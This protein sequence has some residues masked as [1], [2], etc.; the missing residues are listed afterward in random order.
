MSIAGGGL[1]VV[2]AALAALHFYWGFGGVWPGSDPQSLSERVAG[3]S[4]NV[5]SKFLPCAIVAVAL[6]S[7]A[8]IVFAGQG[9]L[10]YGLPELIVYGGYATLILV[11]ALRG[12]APYLT[13]VF[14]YARGTPFFELNRRYYAPLCLLIAAVLVFDYP[15]GLNGA[16]ADL[17]GTET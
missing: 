13:P 9:N 7:A 8:A 12:L 11:F 16:M 3:T 17:F 1:I 5:A 15:P 4:R 2:L 14:N 6:L 10:Q